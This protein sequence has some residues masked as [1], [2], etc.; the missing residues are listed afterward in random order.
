MSTTWEG[1]DC[2]D[3]SRVWV[4]DHNGLILITIIPDNALDQYVKWPAQED[5]I[6]RVANN[7]ELH[8]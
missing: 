8:V 5:V 2:C 1:G 4:M 7:M 6:H 3:S